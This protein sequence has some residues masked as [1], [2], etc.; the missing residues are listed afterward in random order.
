MLCFDQESSTYHSAN[1]REGT[2]NYV[3]CNPIPMLQT[4]ISF[5]RLSGGHN[6][7]PVFNH[8][9]VPQAA[10]RPLALVGPADEMQQDCSLKRNISKVYAWSI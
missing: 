8:T 2:G 4:G 6:K 10:I 5:K 1:L 9:H 3:Y 7:C